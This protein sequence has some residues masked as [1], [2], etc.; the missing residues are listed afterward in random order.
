MPGTTTI[1]KPKLLPEPVIVTDPGWKV[2]LFNDDVTPMEVVVYA[3]Q[4]AAG[5][6]LEVAE[7]ITMEAHSDGSAVVKRGLDEEDAKIICGGL[8]KWSRIDGL[9]PGVHCEAAKDE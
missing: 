1:P 2:V 4:R 5:V 8:R 6:S 9:C 7:M 3:L